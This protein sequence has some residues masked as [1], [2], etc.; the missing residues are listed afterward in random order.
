M[1]T[2]P[3]LSPTVLE[4]FNQKLPQLGRGPLDYKIVKASSTTTGNATPPYVLLCKQ[5]DSFQ[6]IAESCLKADPT[7][8][9][10]LSQQSIGPEYK[11]LSLDNESDLVLASGL[12]VLK[13]ILN[14]ISIWYGDNVKVTCER[15]AKTDLLGDGEKATR[16]DLVFRSAKDNKIVLILEYKRRE[17]IIYRTY[18]RAL[19]WKDKASKKD[20]EAKVRQAKRNAIESSFLVDNSLAHAKQLAVYAKQ[21]ECED[22]ALLNWDHLFLFE[23]NKRSEAEATNTT[24]G[25]T[26][27]L[28]WISEDRELECEHVNEGN[29]RK[30]LLGFI[31]HVCKK[32]SISKVSQ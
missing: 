17:L 29:I 18:R 10:E 20:I 16:V 14:I 25:E 26:A 28:T 19:L 4:C 23:F 6:Q 22:I 5:H 31:L 13:P 1:A 2:A 21:H 7:R 12:F 30:A 15:T 3:D 9:S 27:E 11:Q 8:K 32:H 24:A